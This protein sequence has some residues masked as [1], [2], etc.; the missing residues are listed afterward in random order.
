MSV[1]RESVALVLKSEMSIDLPLKCESAKKVGAK[2]LPENGSLDEWPELLELG[3]LLLH[4]KEMSEDRLAGVLILSEW[5]VRPGH[6]REELRWAQL[7]AGIEGAFSSGALADWNT[8]DW[9]CTKVLAP[10]VE[11]SESPSRCASAL[12][13][14]Q[15]ANTLWQRRAS[16]VFAAVGLARKGDTVFPGFVALLHDNLS[17]CLKAGPQERFVQTG[18]GWVVRELH[19]ADPKTVARFLA[20]HLSLMTT[21]ALNSSLQKMEKAIKTNG[22]GSIGN[23]KSPKNR[24]NKKDYYGSSLC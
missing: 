18:V 17:G 11:M 12:L 19:L 24:K 23:V 22:N 8:V 14:W 9:T 13:S 20:A 7:L 2:Y 16:H 4:E 6:L 21:E 1:I 3:F 15:H 5:L 10:L